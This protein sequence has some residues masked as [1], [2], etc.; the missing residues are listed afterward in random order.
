[1]KHFFILLFSIGVLILSAQSKYKTHTVQKGET[2]YGIAKKYGMTQEQVFELNPNF[3]KEGINEGDIVVIPYGVSNTKTNSRIDSNYIMHQVQPKE[4]LYGLSKRY[5]ISIE[6]IIEEN[7]DVVNGLK[8]GGVIFIPK[9]IKK[10]VKKVKPI[11]AE[12]G[13]K[14]VLVKAQ[15]TVY[16]L[17]KKYGLSEIEFYKLNPVVKEGGLKIGEEIKV[18]DLDYK[19]NTGNNNAVAEDVKTETQVDKEENKEKQKPRFFVYK[20]KEGDNLESLA[21][22]YNTSTE[23]LKKINPEVQNKLVTGRYIILPQ[24]VNKNIS[25]AETSQNINWISTNEVIEN[26]IRIVLI[27]PFYLYANDTIVD[28]YGNSIKAPIYR[29]SKVSIEYYQGFKQAMDT[30]AALGLNLEIKVLDSDND[31]ETIKRQKQKINGFKPHFIV[32]PL[33]P[34]NVQWLAAEFPNIPVVSPLSRATNNNNINN[35]VSC[36]TGISGEWLGMADIINQSY[37]DYRVVFISPKTPKNEVAIELIKRNLTASASPDLVELW[38]G[39]GFPELGFYKK[40]VNDS[41]KKTLWVVTSQDEAFLNDFMTKMYALKVADMKI[42]TTSKVLDI[43]TIQKQYLSALNI[44]ATKQDYIDYSSEETELFIKKY[45]IACGTEPSTYSFNGYDAG[46]YFTLLAA[47]F[48]GI[49]LD[50]SWPTY[51][52]L[53]GG[54][55]FIEAKN[56]GPTNKFINVLEIV[57]YSL[58]RVEF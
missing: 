33:Y 14:V 48:G 34:K 15:E 54:F 42:L 3:K 55:K 39:D 25:A 50:R 23:N 51:Q 43:K 7:P 52:G 36:Y 58:V 11:V 44:I 49:P 21:I 2:I 32:G 8:I 1:M 18:P 9:N 29:K 20:V 47:R 56:N 24:V 6:E 37:L 22:E 17:C 57:D 30:L 26:E 38:A 13:Y 53:G 12:E 45:R 10:P 5:G 16:G 4:T 28:D 19:K 46:I 31:I 35:L 41:T 27:L 40:H